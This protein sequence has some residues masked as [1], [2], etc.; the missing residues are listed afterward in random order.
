[1]KICF[2]WFFFMF[3]L[4]TGEHSLAHIQLGKDTLQT[5]HKKRTRSKLSV[6]N[7]S[8]VSLLGT[9]TEKAFHNNDSKQFSE[10]FDLPYFI[11]RAT[12][13][14]YEDPAIASFKKGYVQSM[15]TIVKSFVEEINADLSQDSYY[16]FIDYYYDYDIKKYRL[17]FR[18]FSEETGLNY[19][20]YV[21]TFRAGEFLVADMYVYTTGEFLTQTLNRF[22]RSSLP[23][24][25]LSK[26][27]KSQDDID[28][29]AFNDA[30]KAKRNENFQ[31]A[32]TAISRIKGALKHD[33]TYHYVAI[34]IASN[35]G[36]KVYLEALSNMVEDY[37]DDPTMSLSCIDYYLFKEEYSKALE[38]LDILQEATGD[39]FLNY[40]RGN[41]AY[42]AA[43][44]E[45]SA[46]SYEKI[47]AEYEEYYNAHTSLLSA[48]TKMKLYQKC[49]P[50]LNTLLQEEVYDKATLITFVEEKDESGENVLEPLVLSEAYQKWKKNN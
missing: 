29:E 26:L 41:I 39:S 24:S 7:D 3:V 35:L 23:K 27:I 2:P 17:L 37:E 40:L 28:F 6:K 45:L 22:Y 46:L 30:L 16:D 11:N 44:Y 5:I 18:L 32:F 1:M 49:I 50:L 4:L 12:D 42:N 25:F 21:L 9:S 8:L 10:K 38:A 36:E 33:K 48:Y 15:K 14:E 31:K 47:I 34:E 13:L 43:N 20:D 19:H